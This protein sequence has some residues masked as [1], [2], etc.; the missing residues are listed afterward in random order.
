[1]ITKWGDW[2]EIEDKAVEEC[3]E[4]IH[5]LQK[6]K[7]FGIDNTHPHTGVKSR[8]TLFT[9]IADVEECLNLLRIKYD[10]KI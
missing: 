10:Y 8:D 7:R 9:E 6:I 1:M 5:I 4:L 3:A 2:V